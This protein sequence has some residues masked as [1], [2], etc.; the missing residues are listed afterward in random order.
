MLFTLSTELGI[1]PSAL[2]KQNINDFCLNTTV[3]FMGLEHKTKQEY[4]QAIEML[5]Q[6]NVQKLDLFKTSIEHLQKIYELDKKKL[7]E[8]NKR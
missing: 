1:L 7:A 6:T 5:D 4:L 2:L 8:S 3:V